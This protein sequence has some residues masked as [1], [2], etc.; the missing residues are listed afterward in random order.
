MNQVPLLFLGDSPTLHSG[1]GRI[2]RELACRVASLP[3]FRVGFLG[4]GGLASRKLPFPQYCFSESEWGENAIQHAWRDFAKGQNGIIFTIWDASRLFWFS[5]PRPELEHVYDFLKDAPFSRWGY[6]PVDATSVGDRLSILS[7]ESILG[8]NRALAYTAWGSDVMSRSTGNPVDWIPHG[9]D[10]DKFQPRDKTAARMSIGL[11]E[12]EIVCGCVMTNQP[13]KDWAVAF[14]TIAELRK[15]FKTLRF[16]VFVD[17]MERS[18]AWSIPALMADFGVEDI[19][20]VVRTGGT[21]DEEMS[22]VYSACDFT[23]LPSSEGFGFPIVESM[24]CGTPVFHGSYGGGAELIPK[25]QWLV[26]PVAWR[27]EGLH[28]SLRPVFEPADWVRQITEYLEGDRVEPD[29]CRASVEYLFWSNLWPSCW[30]RWF[31][32][33]IQ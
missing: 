20:R 10:S 30:K 29:Y 8:F 16:V 33:G 11:K 3:E 15:K 27:I 23:I 32:E 24:A 22:Y 9:I 25:K 5:R 2:G 7:R 1:L 13:R 17:V 14:A 28:N 19:T 26:Q 12:E 21:T 18:H 6:F 31:L 4:R